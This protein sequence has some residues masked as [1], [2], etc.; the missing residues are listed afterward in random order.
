MKIGDLSL[1]EVFRFVVTGSSLHLAL[2]YTGM[3]FVGKLEG[4][5]EK[6][7]AILI[8]GI[9]L[10]YLYRTLIY[11]IILRLVDSAN[12]N[13]VRNY[14]KLQF[15]IKSW[16][17]RNDVWLLIAEKLG[18][19][20]VDKDRLW[21]HSIH[22]LFVLSLVALIG[23]ITAIANGR[24]CTDKAVF[25]TLFVVFLLAAIKSEVS[26]ERRIYRSFLVNGNKCFAEQV[27]GYLQRKADPKRIQEKD[28]DNTR[29]KEQQSKEADT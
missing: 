3:T 13:S 28:P 9:L 17:E 24:S 21:S 5:I 19:E 26:L 8:G 4:S 15:S 18:I 22:M 14:L 16:G 27:Q 12:S 20:S 11:P 2:S 29:P 25:V 23:T 1:S 7:I 6:S 10:Y